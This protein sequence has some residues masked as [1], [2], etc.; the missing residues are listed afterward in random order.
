MKQKK[1]IGAFGLPALPLIAALVMAIG[2]GGNSATTRPHELRPRDKE[3]MAYSMLNAGRV[4]EALKLIGEALEAEPENVRF[5]SAKGEICLRAGR[6][7]EAERAFLRVLELDPYMTE[8]HN[9]L[10]SIY[11]RQGRKNEAEMEFKTALKDPAYPTPE[12]IY[13]N[14]GLLYESQGRSEE[15]VDA[16]RTAVGINP[17]Y[18]RGHFELASMLDRLGKVEEA[19]REYEVASPDP[20][21]ANSGEYHYMIGYAYYRLGDNEK[22]RENLQRAMELAPGSNSAVKAEELLELID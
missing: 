10:G 18:Y 2:C 12:K 19:V 9:A 8:A 21:Y 22:A 16:F 3:K 17:K 1:W 15:A 11:D 4:G 14:L 6:I 5:H 20:E 13:L 7:E